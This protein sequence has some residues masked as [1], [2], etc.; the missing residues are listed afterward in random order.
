VKEIVKND[1]VNDESTIFEKI[2]MSW[3]SINSNDCYGFFRNMMR[4]LRHA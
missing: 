4:Y 2:D 1:Q 3:G